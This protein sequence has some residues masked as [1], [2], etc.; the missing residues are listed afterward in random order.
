MCQRCEFWMLVGGTRFCLGECPKGWVFRSSGECYESVLKGGSAMWLIVGAGILVIL[1]FVAG[2]L[3]FQHAALR[4]QRL[5]LAQMQ[6]KRRV[7]SVMRD[8]VLDSPCDAQSFYQSKT[9]GLSQ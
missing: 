8:A 1:L 7:Q 2:Y 4:R 9:L 5:K 3:V 6:Q